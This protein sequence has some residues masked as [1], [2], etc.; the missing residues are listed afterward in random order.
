MKAG[1]SEAPARDFGRGC[2]VCEMGMTSM[3]TGRW[4]FVV[5]LSALTGPVRAEVESGP[6]VAEKVPAL[7]VFVATGDHEN[8]KVDYAA[9]RKAKPTVYVFIQADKFSRPMARFLR[10]LDSAADRVNATQFNIAF[11]H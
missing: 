8:E 5:L 7:K 9:D 3:R 2:S 11:R 1:R 10:G 6:A 4:T